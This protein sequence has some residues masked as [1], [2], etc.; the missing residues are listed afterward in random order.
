MDGVVVDFADG[1]QK[2]TGKDITG[3]HMKGDA[4]FWEPITKAGVKFWVTLKWMPDGKQLWN[5]IKKFNPDL[6]SAPSREESSRIGKRLWVKR[7]MPGTKLILR[8]AERKQEFATPD[9][10]L[11]DDRTDNIERWRNAGGVGILHITAA[12]TIKEL[13]KLGL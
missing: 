6:L 2:L 5:Y 1:Y 7:N 8:S 13:Q 4:D 10:I 9:S 11:I 3:Q 12:D